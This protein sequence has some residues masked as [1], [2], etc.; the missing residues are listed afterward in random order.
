MFGC[1]VGRG[2]DLF[3]PAKLQVRRM[4]M[5]NVR[6]CT[7]AKRFGGPIIGAFAQ[8]KYDPAA[9]DTEIKIG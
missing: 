4:E 8:N 9:T 3:S 5:S 6:G 7:T 1:L 2:G